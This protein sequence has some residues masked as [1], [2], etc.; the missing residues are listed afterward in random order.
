M[1]VVA[2]PA[3]IERARSFFKTM[4]S[5][6]FDHWVLPGVEFH[7]W[8]FTSTSQSVEETRWNGFFG[9]KPLDFWVNARWEHV[10]I[11]VSTQTFH[12]ETQA[13]IIA[14]IGT[15]HGFQTPMANLRDSKERFWACASLIREHGAIQSPLVV[16]RTQY[17]LY[18]L[19][20]HHRLAAFVYLEFIGTAPIPAWL[21]HPN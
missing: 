8:P 20:G 19:D 15:A 3:E 4:P 14:I 17:G 1:S 16:I 13:R 9:P 6:V 5:E 7:G 21:A 18:L 12:P 11:P 2:D 10:S